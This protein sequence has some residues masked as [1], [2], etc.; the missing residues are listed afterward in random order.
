VQEIATALAEEVEKIS[1]SDFLERH[2]GM[3]DDAEREQVLDRASSQRRPITDVDPQRHRL[4]ETIEADG[5]V[6][7]G[8]VQRMATQ[9]TIV[10]R[11]GG[12]TIQIQ[13]SERPRRSYS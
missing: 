10:D 5:I 1:V 6:V 7:R 2:A 9:V 4:T 8:P 13:V 12:F 11:P 3:L